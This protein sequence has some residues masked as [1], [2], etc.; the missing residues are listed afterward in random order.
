MIRIK[1]T[2]EDRTK[3]LLHRT[4]AKFELEPMLGDQRIRLRSHIDITEE[5]YERVKHIVAPWIAAGM[6]EVIGLSAGEAGASVIKEALKLP[7]VTEQVLPPVPVEQLDMIDDTPP[8]EE[9]IVAT[10]EPAG[11]PVVVEAPPAPAV[12]EKPVD[13][14]KGPGGKKKLF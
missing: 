8:V 7:T 11:A 13:S 3:S 4:A 1:N 9:S 6:V 12:E 2:A 14:K 5:H 10:P